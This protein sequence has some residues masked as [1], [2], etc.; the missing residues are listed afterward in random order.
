MLRGSNEANRAANSC[1]V[2]LT[3]RVGKKRVP[4]THSDVDRKRMSGRR[5]TLLKAFRL[6]AR[7][8]C[9]RRDAVEQLVVVRDFLDPLWRN[10]PPAQDVCEKWADVVAALGTTESDDED[11]VEQQWRLWKACPAEAR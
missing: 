6:P 3:E 11:C 8:G 4:V 5:E 2:H 1:V 9:Q 10:A 7:D